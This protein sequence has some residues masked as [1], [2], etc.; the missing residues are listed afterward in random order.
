MPKRLLHTQSDP[1][2]EL[3]EWLSYLKKPLR[4]IDEDGTK[5]VVLS[6][7]EFRQLL[8]HLRSLRT[9]VAAIDD[10]SVS[11]EDFVAELRASGLLKA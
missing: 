2:L 7:T 3:A 11:Q 9:V 5:S 4:Y 8:H 6:M 1:E 10:E